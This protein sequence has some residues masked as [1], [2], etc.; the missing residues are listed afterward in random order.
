MRVEEIGNFSDVLFFMERHGIAKEAAST[1]ATQL[2]QWGVS[3]AMDR[4]R[5]TLPAPNDL[6]AIPAQ[7][8]LFEEPV[9]AAK[10]AKPKEPKKVAHSWPEGFSL[11]EAMIAFARDRGFRAQEI[12]RM[13]E[14]FRDRNQARGEKYADWKAAWRTWVGNQVEFRSRD[15]GARGPNNHIDG[16]L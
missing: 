2:F 7:S 6:P 9:K 8:A 14:R 11:D 10:P 16:R 1:I 12:Q 4:L 15:Q 13:W 5:P 3:A